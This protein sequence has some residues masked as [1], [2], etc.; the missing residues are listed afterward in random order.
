LLLLASGF[1][2]LARGVA[3][4]HVRVASQLRQIDSYGFHASDASA[5]SVPRQSLVVRLE[6]FAERIGRQ[7]SGQGTLAP[8]ESRVLRAA[9]MYQMTPEAFHGYRVIGTVAFP[10]FVLLLSLAGGSI[11]AIMVMLIVI[12]G[13]LCWMLPP[14]MVRTRAKKRMDEL[15]RA[16]PELIDVLT[17]TVEAGLG[18]AGSLRM[19]AARFDGP[20]GQ[21]LRLM[22]HEQ[23]M[24]LSTE[25]AMSNLLARC[26]TP[27]V[28]AFARSV[29]QGEALG[30]S[31]GTMLRN[32][33]GETRKRRRQVAREKI[34]KVPVKMLFPLVFFIFPAMFIVLLYPAMSST[35]HVLSGH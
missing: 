17:A 27:S 29:T 12:G 13:L 32:L 34:I 21:E 10:G 30:V 8:V 14:S 19:V 31:I 6:P 2:L 9:G 33:A 23:S 16:L 20:L 28:R 22:Q 3:M 26:D 7:F 25:Q 4:R 24:G 11:S 35:L 18:F 5:E 1:G 15:D